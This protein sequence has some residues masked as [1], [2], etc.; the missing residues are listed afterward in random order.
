[1]TYQITCPEA[2][3]H[4]TKYDLAV[5]VDR[6]VVDIGSVDCLPVSARIRTTVRI[7]YAVPYKEHAP[8]D[9]DR[10]LP[11]VPAD[12]RR[13]VFASVSSVAELPPD[14]LERPSTDETTWDRAG[15]AA[16][17]LIPLGLALCIP[18]LLALPI[19][20]MRSFRST[21]RGLAAP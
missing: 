6:K 11:D 14:L 3:I 17:T 15:V 19:V 12:E 13:A 16:A 1:M 2:F 5:H 7:A 18:P 21:R 8:G 9:R 20:A 4:G 10:T